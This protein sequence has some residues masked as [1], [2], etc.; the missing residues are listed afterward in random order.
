MV[1]AA[2]C[3]VITSFL[4]G[5]MAARPAART[6]LTIPRT[7]LRVEAV[8]RFG[9]P[10]AQGALVEYGDFECPACGVFNRDILPILTTQYI[11]RGLLQIMFVN[12][13]LPMHQHARAAASAAVCAAEEGK[14]WEMHEAL[15]ADQEH[16]DGSALVARALTLKLNLSKFQTCLTSDGPSTV[17][18]ESARAFDAHMTSTPAFLVGTMLP[19]G[20]IKAVKG[21]RGAQSVSQFTDAIGAVLNSTALR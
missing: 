16:L 19:D 6:A 12:D 11:N 13:P 14:G 2:A 8:V 9:D 17:T 1:I 5:G 20:R 3:V 18:A 7:P 10:K 4:W 21:I 15:Y